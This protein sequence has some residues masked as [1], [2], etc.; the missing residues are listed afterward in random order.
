MK[1]HYFILVSLFCFIC[2]I[3]CD[4]NYDPEPYCNT[5]H[6]IQL[7]KPE[8]K[9]YVI[10]TLD[11]NSNNIVS[12]SGNANVLKDGALPYWDLTDDYLLIDWRWY[13]FPITHNKQYLLLYPWSVV[14]NSYYPI[15]NL[16]TCQYI[17]DPIKVSYGIDMAKVNAQLETQELY[18]LAYE[19]SHRE[20]EGDEE[21]RKKTAYM[22]SVW[23]YTQQQLITIIEQDRLKD[24]L[25]TNKFALY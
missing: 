18:Q 8:Y 2:T 6:V 5:V 1:N 21:F 24:V 9:Q 14:E 3:S 13:L 25:I 12:L 11:Y 15:W 23:A 20:H 22:D 17:E 4:K 16:D 10:A 7:V 19:D